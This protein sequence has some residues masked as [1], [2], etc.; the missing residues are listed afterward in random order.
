MAESPQ[1]SF[2]FPA[3]YE[4]KLR[5]EG[6][7]HNMSPGEYARLLV[8]H[9]LEREELLDVR[10]DLRELREDVR[11]LASAIEELRRDFNRA[12]T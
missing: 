11:Q 5:A 10:Q 1:V 2:R 9:H 4:R 8:I 3:H 12:V 7:K 6:E